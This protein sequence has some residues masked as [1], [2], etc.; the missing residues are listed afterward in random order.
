MFI[1]ITA[2]EDPETVCMYMEGK[3]NASTQEAFEGKFQEALQRAQMI[4]FDFSAVEQIDS[5]G[6]GTLIRCFHEGLTAKVRLVLLH[7][8]SQPGSVIELTKT[9]QVFE[10]LS[11]KYL[12]GRV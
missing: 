3:L 1:S 9:E 8:Q 6:L 12:S 5:A 7:L 11:P 2:T 10:L 4:L